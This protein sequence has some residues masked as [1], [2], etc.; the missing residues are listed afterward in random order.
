MVK[1]TTQRVLLLFAFAMQIWSCSSYADSSLRDQIVEADQ[2]LFDAFNGCD[3]PTFS[4]MLAKD[5][6]FY[7]DTGGVTGYSHSVNVTKENCERNL[8][9]TRTLVDGSMEVYPVKDFGAMQIAKHQFCHLE[10]GRM[11][12]GTFGFAHVWKQTDEGWKV[13]R[14][15]SYGH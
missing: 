14:V 12:C 1:L 6:E 9:L 13:V 11:D 7:H 15:L 2:R 10:N 3:I 5:L 8:G 4:G